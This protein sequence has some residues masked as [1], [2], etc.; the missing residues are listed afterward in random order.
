MKILSMSRIV[1]V[2]PRTLISSLLPPLSVMLLFWSFGLPYMVFLWNLLLIRTRLHP[3]STTTLVL[4]PLIIQLII[5]MLASHVKTKY[6]EFLLLVEVGQSQALCP[7]PLQ[8]KHV[9]LAAL[10]GCC[11]SSCLF[12]F[13]P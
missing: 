11:L 4:C 2:S 10:F 6:L 5:T 7:T 3:E 1:Y 9:N 13:V 8:L 12:L